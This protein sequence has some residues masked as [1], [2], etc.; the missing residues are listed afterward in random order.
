MAA[1]NSMSPYVQSDIQE[2]LAGLS[3]LGNNDNLVVY[4]DDTSLPRFYYLN[5]KTSTVSAKNLVANYTYKSEMN[6]CSA[7]TLDLVM[8]HVTDKFKSD[9]YG[10]VFWSHGS[11]WIEQESNVKRYTFGVDNRKNNANDDAGDQ[12]SI[13]DM[14]S[15][16]RKYNNLEFVFFDACFMQ[17]IE[18]AYELKDCANYIL[19]SPAETPGTGAPYNYIMLPM[20]AK[21]FYPG[22]VLLSIYDYQLKQDPYGIVVSAIKTSE[23]D[24]FAKTMKGIFAKHTFLDKDYSKCLNYYVADEWN[25]LM[26]LYHSPDMYDM[27]GIMKENLDEAEMV[28]WQDAFDRLVV[29]CYATESWYSAF[30]DGLMTVDGRPCGGVSMFLPFDKYKGEQFYDDYNKTAWGKLFNIK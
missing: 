16:L 30:E 20:F 19:A 12:M 7:E 8:K 9:T 17:S 13:I 26:V 22:N 2:M 6:S 4:V 18:V 28:E 15:V 3:K 1:E 21:P 10:I 11:G 27:E 23:L 29:S 25:Q 24:N 14:A 5:K